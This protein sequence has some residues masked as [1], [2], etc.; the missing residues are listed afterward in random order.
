VHEVTTLNK[1][2]RFKVALDQIEVADFAEVHGL[3]ATTDVLEYSEGG[4]NEQFHKL[5]GGT[6]FAPIELAFGTSS[7]TELYDWV[8][9]ALDGAIERKNGSIMA[10]NQ[11]GTVVARWEFRGA[12]PMRYEGPKLGHPMGETAIGRLVLAHSGFFLQKESDAAT[13][14]HQG[15][16]EGDG[17]GISKGTDE[18]GRGGGLP[19]GRTKQVRKDLKDDGVE[20][21]GDESAGKYLDDQAQ[22]QGKDPKSVKSS[23]VGDVLIIRPEHDDDPSL[24]RQEQQH[25]Q[26]NRTNDDDQLQQ[27]ET[28]SRDESKQEDLTPEE[29]QQVNDEQA[30]VSGDPG[31]HP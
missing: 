3:T 4:I 11:D 2:F 14:V 29:Q 15:G 24:M 8:K 27:S 28:Q 5:I 23:S 9:K 20:V 6:R 31:Y 7:S 25:I 10:I 12:W 19:G 16:G 26:Q 1:G 13:R 22:S 30:Q 18:G 17:T 21:W